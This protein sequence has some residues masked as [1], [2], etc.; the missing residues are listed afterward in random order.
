MMHVVCISV[1]SNETT[2]LD[3]TISSLPILIDSYRNV[4]AVTGLQHFFKENK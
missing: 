2:L 1:V 4:V 3:Y